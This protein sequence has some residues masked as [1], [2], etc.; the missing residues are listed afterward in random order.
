V[1]ENMLQII[2]RVAATV[3]TSLLL[4]SVSGAQQP[5]N[6][7]AAPKPAQ[8]L[9]AKKVFIS[10]ASAECPAFYCTAPDQPY[11]EFYF[12]MKSWGKYELV[13]APADADLV[14]EIHFIFHQDDGLGRVRLVILDPK[15][16]MALWTLDERLGA[17]ARES[18]GRKNFH[19]AMS[20]LVNDVEKLAATDSVAK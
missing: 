4:L 11:N 15:T 8:V 17:A 16:R 18:S 10:N 6:S 12:G 1:E 19:K 2:E 3:V 20:A 5:P 13:E 9:A 7:A 14:L